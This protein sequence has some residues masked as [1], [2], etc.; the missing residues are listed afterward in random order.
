MWWNYNT[1]QY[2]EIQSMIRITIWLFKR[3]ICILLILSKNINVKNIKIA[4]RR[5]EMGHVTIKS[6]DVKMTKETVSTIK[7]RMIK[8]GEIEEGQGHGNVL[9]WE[10]AL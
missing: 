3:R 4:I 7:G 8:Q 5:I 9:Q 1:G 10:V 6:M 2:Y